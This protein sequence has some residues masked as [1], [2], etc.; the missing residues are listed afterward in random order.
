M[1]QIRGG[2]W[3]RQE[4]AQHFQYAREEFCSFAKE[5]GLAEKEL[6]STRKEFGLAKLLSR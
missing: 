4:T 2:G 6:Y 5:F 3:Q 1:H